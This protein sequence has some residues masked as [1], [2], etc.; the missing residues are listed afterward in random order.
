MCG[1]QQVLKYVTISSIVK[2]RGITFW[3]FWG[4]PGGIMGLWP[5]MD[6]ETCGWRKYLNEEV[7]GVCY[8]PSNITSNQGERSGWRSGMYGGKGECVE[9]D[10]A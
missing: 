3:L 7:H 4:P 9:I 6:K 5:K 10:L 2:T 1:L 8:S